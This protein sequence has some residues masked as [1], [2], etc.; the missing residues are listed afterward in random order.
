MTFIGLVSPKVPLNAIP[1]EGKLYYLSPLTFKE[2]A[3]YVL[4]Y[5]YSELEKQEIVTRN[6]PQEVRNKI[7]ADT[8][9]E[10]KNKVWEYEDEHG[11]KKQVPLS[12]ETPEVQQSCNTLEGIQEQL[13][14]GLRVNHPDIT[15]EQVCK[16]VTLE[17]YS[18][19]LDKILT[20]MGISPELYDETQEVYKE[21]KKSKPISQKIKDKSRLIGILC[22]SI[23]SKL[24][25]L[26]RPNLR[27]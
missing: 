18:K 5:Q 12:W 4:W 19:M 11:A 26:I 14:L 23:L 3:E 17:N 8:H 24:L 27:N 21:I 20:A 16:I 22:L 9:T 6:L 10:C 15:K 7:L 25:G 1:H 13:Y 2:M